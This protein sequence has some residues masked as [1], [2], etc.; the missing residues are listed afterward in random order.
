[1]AASNQPL[2][3]HLHIYKPQLTSYM[4]ILHRLS[5]IFLSLGLLALVYWFTSI[6]LGHEAYQQANSLL[7]SWFGRLLLFMWSFALF[8]HLANG[9]RHLFWDAGLG[10]DIK[11]VYISGRFTWGIAII[12][13]LTSWILA[14][15]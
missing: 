10:F 14:L 8:Y 9:T 11:M 12:L 7:G 4:S 15:I 1:M 13:T 3:P 2:S 5:G 6:A